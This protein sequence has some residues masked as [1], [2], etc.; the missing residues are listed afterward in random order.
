MAIQAVPR[1][2][3]RHVEVD[4]VR[5]FYR[6]SVPAAM[7]AEDAPVLLLLHG[8]PSAVAGLAAQAHTTG[9][10]RLGP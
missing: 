4:G 2:R 8:F 10:H 3:H 9:T 6:E 1:I 7:P 5:V